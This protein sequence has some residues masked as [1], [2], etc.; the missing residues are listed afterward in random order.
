MRAVLATLVRSSLALAAIAITL[1]GLPIVAMATP[2]D[3]L[4]AYPMSWLYGRLLFF[5]WAI[6]W[7]PAPPYIVQPYF[8]QP[9]LF[10]SL[11]WGLMA[12]LTTL[13]VHKRL[14]KNTLVAALLVCSG[15]VLLI[16]VVIWLT[17]ISI[18]QLKM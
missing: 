3:I 15:M 17:G 14:V 10:T 9:A 7:A 8:E 18:D 13:L 2:V 6:K 12:L 5:F 4:V 11:Q 16:Q 1:Y